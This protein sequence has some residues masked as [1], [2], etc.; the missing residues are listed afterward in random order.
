VRGDKFM[1]ITRGIILL[2]AS[3]L[4]AGLASGQVA[5][6]APPFGSFSGGP[7]VI[8]LA[9]LN[10]HI[11]VPVFSKAGRGL[12]FG[13]ELGYDASVWYPVGSS[14]SK[15]WQPLASWGWIQQTASVTG[16]L[17]ATTTNSQVVCFPVH[18]PPYYKYVN[19]TSNFVYHDPSG[20]THP[21]L[22]SIVTSTGSCSNSNTLSFTA[23]ATDASGF[24]LNANSGNSDTVVTPSGTVIGPPYL[25]SSG[26]ASEMDANGNEITI[27]GSGV[28][29]DTLGSTALT[30]AGS[31]TPAS[32]TTYTYTAPSGSNVAYTVKY[33]AYTV[34]TNYGCS[35]I[36]EYGPTA[37]NLPSE[38]DLPNGTK[39]TLA[40][41]AT[42]GF[43]GDVTG[44]LASVTLPTGGTISYT[45]TGSNN[46]ITCTD[47]STAGLTRVTPDGTWTYSRSG[48]TTTVTAPQMPY[49]LASNQEVYTFNSGG[50]ETQRKIYQG[51]ASSGTLLRTANTTWATNNTPL[52]KITILEDN[53]TQFE[54]ETT[55]D[56]YGNLLTLKEH[57]LGTGAPGSVL[58]T[59]T[60]TYLSTSAYISLNIV[61]RVTEKT[62]ADSTGTTQYREDTAYDGTTISPCP[63]GV[64]QHDDAGH[65]C[66]FTT[67]GNPTS[68]TTYAN[69]AVPSG[70]VTKNSYFDFF[71]NEVQVDADCCQV[72]RR[73][74]SA[75]TAYSRPDN[76]TRGA[77]G[78]PQLTTSFV[79]NTYTGQISLLTDP[80]NQVTSYA[81]DTML[82]PVGATRP[83][84]SQTT[85]SY[86]DTTPTLSTTQPIDAN[87]AI[88]T[89]QAFDGLGRSSTTTTADASSNIYSIT[90]T[91]Y[92][93]AGRPYM[94]S[95]PYTSSPQYWTKTQFDGLGRVTKTVLQDNSPFTYTYS[96][97][98]ATITDPAGHQTKSQFDGIGRLVSMFEPDPTNGNSLT[99]QTT[100]AYTV[101]NRQATITQ[102]SQTRTFH[103]DGMGRLASETHP[104][105]GT[106][107]YQYN[108]FSKL[109]QRTDNRGVIT[110]YSYDTLN[111]PYQVIYNVGTTGVPATPTVTYAFGTNA[112]QLNNGRLLSVTDGTGSKTYTYDQMARE[113]QEAQVI[114]GT[115]YTIGYQYNF[116]SEVTS[117][118]YPSGRVIQKTPDA[119]GRL[120]SIASGT[121]TYMSGITYDASFS[122]TGLS[123]GNGVTATVNHSPDRLQFQSI[124][125]SKSGTTIFGESYT[126]ASSGGN[127]GHIIGTTDAVDS[128]RNMTYTYDALERLT[129]ATSQGSTNYPQWGLSWTYDRYGNRTA[130]TVTAGTAPPNSVTVS[131]TTNQI[132]TSGYAYDASGNMTGDGQNTL[133]YDAENRATSST[134]SAS[135]TYSYEASGLRVQKTSGGVATVYIFSGDE[136]I[137]EYA[138][139]VLSK[140][141][142][143]SRNSVIAEHDNGTL[144][145][146]GRD[147]L[148]TRINLDTGGNLSGQQGHFPY[149]EDW[150]LQNTTTGQHFTTYAR[151]SESGNDY[152]KHRF[153]VNRLGRFAIVDP[154]RP[155]G[156]NPQ[157]LNRYG[158]VAGEPV[159]RSDPSGRT[160]IMT[161]LELPCD[162]FEDFGNCPLLPPGIGEGGG[163]GGGG[164]SSYCGVGSNPVSE[165]EG[166]KCVPP[167][168]PVVTPMPKCFCQMK[169]RPVDDKLV[170]LVHGTHSFWYVQDFSGIQW[171][172]SSGPSNPNGSGFLNA[173][174]NND[175]FTGVDNVYA[176]TWFDSGLSTPNCYS[177]EMM[178]GMD[179]GWLNN[180]VTYHATTGPNSNSF[181]HL[182]ANGGSF[183]VSAP[184]G[185][186]GWA[187]GGFF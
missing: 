9:N 29:T 79:Y 104:E 169:Y 60:Y 103:Y 86:N 97:A 136:L 183:K 34:R 76:V 68:F 139:G 21:F 155:R 44:R 125:Y 117:T 3:L 32:P 110:T 142:V 4:T 92:D 6:G 80:N 150:Y 36:S 131:P 152:A 54:A 113:T 2:L 121:T 91:Q 181:A 37:Q 62:I 144:V 41:E 63:S 132:T 186:Y 134:G 151:D 107:S 13:S 7:D 138:N 158:Y 25:T 149:G 20:T 141:Y 161:P 30:I 106:T 160:F 8:N 164:P 64:Q 43:A 90:Q 45:Y 111:R 84:T 129:S 15:T 87:H 65:G 55:F 178:I 162:E 1:K 167:P 165:G 78:G 83:D 182:L 170:K 61:D 112:T 116:A 120:A 52:T 81:Y 31:G 146:H 56:N 24:Q 118:T 99:L 42:P 114:G 98:S 133:V 96:L 33:T 137:A 173:F 49:D 12:P 156:S 18:N 5:T 95:N 185:S 101:L 10:V 174:H 67:R 19:T 176:T 57:D 51:S 38:I 48:S 59:T 102:G 184:P 105:T 94:V 47:G 108:S 27:N 88:V 157:L 128:G 180:T 175:V 168:L 66:S 35:G 148:S 69:A 50:L 82:R 166:D 89:I 46:G 26:P 77:S 123:Y 109:T 85:L 122:P 73:S 100:F 74:L 115:Q 72:V 39:Y 147:H 16:Y 179:L 127:D 153:N 75:A 53:S 23:T 154:S 14:G 71:G 28:F 135:G 93:P 126:Y 172:L 177:A 119:V 70:G 159:G 143:N 145:Y 40:Y 163:G 140:E 17:T 124:S 171:I 187:L 58:R 11:S 130:Q 22:G